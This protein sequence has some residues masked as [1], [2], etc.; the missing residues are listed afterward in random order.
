MILHSDK[1]KEGQFGGHKDK[2]ILQKSNKEEEKVPSYR[3]HQNNY[4]SNEGEEGN[5]K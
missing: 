3:R 4:T 1:M 5:L 2:K